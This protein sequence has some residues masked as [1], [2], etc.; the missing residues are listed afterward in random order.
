MKKLDTSYDK[1]LDKAQ[2]IHFIGI[3][4]SGMCPLAEILLSEGKTITGSDVDN[5]SDTVNRIRGLGVHV[6]IGQRAENIGDAELVVYTAAISPEHPELAAALAAGI[7][8]IP[9]AE[10]LGGIMTE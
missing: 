10:Y 2:R 9:R 3:G 5:E 8:C 4:G 7:P 1:L 6:D